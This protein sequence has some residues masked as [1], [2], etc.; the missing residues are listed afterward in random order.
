[1]WVFILY[2]IYLQ[3][4]IDLFTRICMKWPDFVVLCRKK[5]IFPNKEQKLGNLLNPFALREFCRETCLEASRAVSTL[6]TT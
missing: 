5:Y 3:H 4:S 1:M 2:S 6:V